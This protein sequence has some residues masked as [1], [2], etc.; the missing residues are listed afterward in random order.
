M[1]AGKEYEVKCAS[2]SKEALF[3]LALPSGQTQLQAW[4]QDGEGKDL[5]GAFYVKVRLME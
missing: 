4:F 2:G 1:V 5:C 3:H